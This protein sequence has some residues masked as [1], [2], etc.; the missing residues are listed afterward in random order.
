MPSWADVG[1]IG[2]NLQDLAHWTRSGKDPWVGEVSHPSGYRASVSRTHE[3]YWWQASFEGVAFDSYGPCNR[4]DFAREY[5]I[6]AIERH[7]AS[8][9]G[10]DRVDTA[11]DKARY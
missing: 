6:E 11:A 4:G 7:V 5:A 2:M 9:D 3:G 8:G 1:R 10:P